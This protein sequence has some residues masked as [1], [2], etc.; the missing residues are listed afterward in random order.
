[1]GPLPKNN[2]LPLKIGRAIKSSFPTN[3]F[4]IL[5]LVWGSEHETHTKQP[6][7]LHQNLDLLDWWL[8]KNHKTIPVKWWFFHGDFRPMGSNP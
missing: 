5:L 7:K 6:R 2:S 1:M 8:D 3:I 4:Q